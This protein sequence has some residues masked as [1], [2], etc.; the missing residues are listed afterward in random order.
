VIASMPTISD[1]MQL[2]Y[3]LVRVD[4][5]PSPDTLVKLTVAGLA[6]LSTFESTVDI[7]LRVLAELSARRASASY[8]PAE[9]IEVVVSGPDL[10]RDLKLSDE[11][12]VSLLP[13]LLEGE[14]ATWH[15]HGGTD[16]RGWLHKPSTWL[17]RFHGVGDVSDYLSRLRTW[18]VPAPPAAA[19]VLVSPLTVV[20]AFDYLDAVWRGRFGQRLLVVPGA[21]RPARLAFD[22]ANAMEFDNRLSALGEIIKGFSIPGGSKAGSLQQMEAFLAQ[23]LGADSMSRVRS[24]L[25]VLHHVTHIRNAGQH[26]EATTKAAAAMPTF[27]LRFPITD[28]MA[29]WH[30]VRAHVAEALDAIRDEIDDAP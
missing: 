20:T 1:G 10:V 8:R 5:Y 28:Y 4:R 2:R 22:A 9:V 14:P 3:S 27:G 25:T 17:R 26:I 16:E 15:G 6:H 18:L 11:P 24:A 21:E 13:D 7:F 19:P 12:F 30:S 29:A 23:H